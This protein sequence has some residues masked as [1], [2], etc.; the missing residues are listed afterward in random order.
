M[1]M[2]SSFARRC[3]LCYSDNWT[4]IYDPISDWKHSGSSQN[5]IHEGF[6]P[7]PQGTRTVF[8]DTEEPRKDSSATRS[9]S[10]EPESRFQREKSVL[11]ERERD[12]RNERSKT[13]TSRPRST[14]DAA[15]R[16]I[17]EQSNRQSGREMEKERD[18]RKRERSE[19]FGLIDEYESG[20]ERP[21]DYEESSS[22]RRRLE[23]HE[24]H[25]ELDS[26]SHNETDHRR[27]ASSSPSI[28]QQSTTV[29]R[30]PKY[31]FL[32]SKMHESEQPQKLFDIGIGRIK[33]LV[34]S[35]WSG[36]PQPSDH[37]KP[38]G[39]AGDESATLLAASDAELKYIQSQLRASQKQ[40]E[41]KESELRFL[42]EE[43]G[44]QRDLRRAE[45]TSS[46]MRRNGGVTITALQ[47]IVNW[48]SIAPKR[49][50]R[51]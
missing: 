9:H 35:L 48:L 29:H 47:A 31:P 27:N 26:L 4:S 20:D 46:R 24:E 49:G 8:P 43:V 6:N 45:R 30:P 1:V 50:L 32:V 40:C 28:R 16:Q 51:S 15:R 12:R 23:A 13:D 22:K 34:P 37:N 14:F 2:M 19:S 7:P 21:K 39:E 17:T 38:A 42:Q 3:L 18:R 33:S 11:S 44:R 36:T 25:D 10:R 41:D 5:A